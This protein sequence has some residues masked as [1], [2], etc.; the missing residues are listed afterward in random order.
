MN[1]ALTKCF[2]HTLGKRTHQKKRKFVFF[3]ERIQ[4]NEMFRSQKNETLT[5]LL[6]STVMSLGATGTYE[7]HNYESS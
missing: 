1:E 4:K 6:V 3:L 2:M 7:S 5:S